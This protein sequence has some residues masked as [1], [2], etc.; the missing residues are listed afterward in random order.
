[1]K[2]IVVS[3]HPDDETLGAGGTI[4]KMISQ[5][6][7]VCWLNITNMKQEYG[8]SA[9]AVRV[10]A[11]EIQRVRQ[12]TGYTAFHDLG[13]KPTALEQYPREALVSA[14]K[15]VFDE[16]RPELVFL[17]FPHDAHSDHGIVYA[18]ALACTK[19]FRAPYVKKVL[20]MDIISETNYASVPFRPDCYSDITPFI[21]KKID[22]VSYYQSELQPSPF[23]R[24]KESILSQA[25]FHGAACYR[26]YAEAF[27]LVKEIIP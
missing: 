25:V 7:E 13:L 19:A 12:A 11:D 15:R 1:M 16:E 2:A 22:I 3:P 18:S 9:Q 26:K 23:P 5:G 27:Q 4:L 24:S 17:P 10:R 6:S 20:C 21:E 8:Y 14:I